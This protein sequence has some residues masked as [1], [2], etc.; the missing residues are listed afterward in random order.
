MYAEEGAS[1]SPEAFRDERRRLQQE[2]T[3]AEQSLEETSER[4]HV[5]EADLVMALELATDVQAFY[6][7]ADEGTKRSLNHASSTRSMC[8]PS[9]VISAEEA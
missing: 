8:R 4:L 3:A 2:L 9:G 6:T 7:T 5:E 1:V